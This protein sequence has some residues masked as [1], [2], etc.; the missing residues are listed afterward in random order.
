MTTVPWTYTTRADTGTTNV[1]VGIWLFLAS[2]AMLFGSLIS[3][4]VLLRAGGATWAGTGTL[5]AR[6][7]LIDTVIVLAAAMALLPALKLSSTAA[8]TTS[9]LLAAVFVALKLLEFNVRID[10]GL[11]P[12]SNVLLASWFVLTGVHAAH[13]AAG[14]AANVYVLLAA[15]PAEHAAARVHALRLYWSFVDLVWLVLLVAFYLL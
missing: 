11:T 5:D 14:I 10:A 2:E 6:S 9:S 4:Y 3:A 1:R 7:A 12:A 15:G 8:L 13:V